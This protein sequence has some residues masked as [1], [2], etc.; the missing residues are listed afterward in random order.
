MKER[1][2]PKSV[3][4]V[5]PVYN[6]EK[7]LSEAIES[8][9][10]QTVAPAEIIV[11]DDGSTDG[12]EQVAKKYASAIR[13]I[14]QPNRGSGAARNAGTSQSI[15]DFLAFLDADDVWIENKLE[16]QLKAHEK[17]PALDMIFGHAQQFGS[18][19]AAGPAMPGVIPSALLVRK[20]AFHR[21]GPFLETLRLAD[22]PHWYLQ[23]RDAGLR[24]K[25]LEEIVVKRRLHE[26]NMGVTRRDALS[27]YA[28][29]LKISLDRRRQNKQTPE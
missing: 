17:D 2:F 21:A 23:A 14:S 18:L 28:H 12:T 29:A 20:E 4:V 1:D 24:E 7:Y 15:G 10:R 5:I 27:E 25:I 6:G 19:N 16:L 26:A 11:V 9:L 3:S 8:V 22:F 13:Y